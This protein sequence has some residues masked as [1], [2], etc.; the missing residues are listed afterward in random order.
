MDVIEKNILSTVYAEYFAIFFTDDGVIVDCQTSSPLLHFAKTVKKLELI[1]S[2]AYLDKS[3]IFVK[4]HRILTFKQIKNNGFHIYNEKSFFNSIKEEETQRLIL[5]ATHWLTWDTRLQYCTKCGTELQS[6]FDATEKKCSLCNLSFYPKLSPA[7]MVLIQKDNE[8]LL[9]RS[10]HF[11]PGVYSAI[12]GF[13]DI[14]ETAEL[15]VHRE[16]KEEVGLEVSE[17]EYF[18]SQSWPFPDSFMIAFKAKYLRGEINIDGNEI[19]DAQWFNL[20]NL[21]DLPPVSSISR[22]LIE[23]FI[24]KP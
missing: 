12:A 22:K 23:S 17:L 3:I 10:A 14:G 6:V 7:I 13:I 16:V 24:L 4:C 1:I 9:A 2:S 18:G 11:K 19:E 15:A 21:P 5:R 20:N 8:I